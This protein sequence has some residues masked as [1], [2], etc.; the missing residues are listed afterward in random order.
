MLYRSSW[1]TGVRKCER[2]S[3][4][5][6]KVSEEGRTYSRHRAEVPWSPE[7]AHGRAGCLPVAHGYHTADPNVQPWRSPWISLE[8]VYPM[9][10]TWCWSR[11]RAS[12]WRNNREKVSR[13]DCNCYSPFSCTSWEGKEAEEVQG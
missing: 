9:G 6:T 4:A 8:G 1:N 2:N 11:G 12:E 13:T 5:G 7:E 10:G 3:P